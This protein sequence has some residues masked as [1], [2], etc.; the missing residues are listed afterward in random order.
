[1]RFCPANGVRDIAL[2]KSFPTPTVS[3]LFWVVIRLA[4]GP[5]LEAWPEPTAPMAPEPLG[6]E[7]FTPVKLMTVIDD[8]TDWERFAETCTLVMALDAKA[9]QISEVPD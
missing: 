8:A 3:E 7:M 9:R 4:E 2:S 6:P 5:P 1:M